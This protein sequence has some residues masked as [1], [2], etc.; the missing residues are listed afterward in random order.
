LTIEEFDKNIEEWGRAKGLIPEDGISLLATKAQYLKVAEE[1][2]ELYEADSFCEVAPLVG[3]DSLMDAIGDT[4]V[5]LCLLCKQCGIDFLSV[6]RDSKML[7]RKAFI[8]D[9]LSIAGRLARGVLPTLEITHSLS[10]LESIARKHEVIFMECCDMAWNVIR[11]RT[12]KTI[13]GVFIKD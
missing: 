12:G 11:E 3:L 7:A 6:Y 9:I 8:H 13:N 4:A 5:T 2:G 1:A 10:S